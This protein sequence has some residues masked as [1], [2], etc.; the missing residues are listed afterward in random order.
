LESWRISGKEKA[1][2]E[3]RVQEKKNPGILIEII[4]SKCPNGCWI[5]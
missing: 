2:K 1:G 5:N 4:K 3:F